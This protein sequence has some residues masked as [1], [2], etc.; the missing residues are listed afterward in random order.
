MKAAVRGQV[1]KGQLFLQSN[2][3][4]LDQAY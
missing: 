3:P 2:L 4:Q 1:P